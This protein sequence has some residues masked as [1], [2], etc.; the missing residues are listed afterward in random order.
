MFK[1]VKFLG[2]LKID[3]CI[4]T[5]HSYS[6]S[7]ELFINRF[8]TELNVSECSAQTFWNLF[9]RDLQDMLQGMCTMESI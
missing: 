2:C 9:A 6:K 8:P 4:F 1:T 3:L 5:E 7:K